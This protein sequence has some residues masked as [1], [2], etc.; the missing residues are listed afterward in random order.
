MVPVSGCVD[1]THG[2]PLFCRREVDRAQL[3]GR[4]EGPRGLPPEYGIKE[5]RRVHD[6]LKR[7]IY[8]FEIAEGEIVG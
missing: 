1:D 8:I 6:A 2:D 5:G 4:I 3:K 7:S